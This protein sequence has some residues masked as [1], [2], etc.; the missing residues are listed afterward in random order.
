MADGGAGDGDYAGR[1]QHAEKSAVA[2]W[3]FK[4]FAAGV[5]AGALLEDL[6]SFLQLVEGGFWVGHYC[7]SLKSAAYQCLPHLEFAYLLD[8]A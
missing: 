4:R 2:V 7:F 6:G 8:L 3:Q 5:F 1:N